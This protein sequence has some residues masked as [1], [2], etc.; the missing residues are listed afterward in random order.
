MRKNL[1][2]NQLIAVL[3]ILNLF[4]VALLVFYPDQ[5]TKQSKREQTLKQACKKLNSSSKKKLCL[6]TLKKCKLE[7]DIYDSNLV[8]FCAAT[9]FKKNEIELSKRVCN[10]LNESAMKKACF[11][12]VLQDYSK[13][14]S[15][16]QCNLINT[17]K[18]RVE[19]RKHIIKRY[20]VYKAL[21][22]CN[23]FQNPQIAEGCKKS[24]IKGIKNE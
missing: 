11:A 7:K 18:E 6:S 14:A 17:N 24:I 23:S 20:N 21:K 12:R 5:Q 10:A 4:A 8:A 2:F 19:C 22:E 13:N 16:R 9:S 1:N 15:L 3:V